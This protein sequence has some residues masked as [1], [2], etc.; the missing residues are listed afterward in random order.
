MVVANPA[1]LLTIGK[2]TPLAT[3]WQLFLVSKFPLE[4]KLVC[5]ILSACH[6][7]INLSVGLVFSKLHLVNNFF[8]IIYY[9]TSSLA[10]HKQ[11]VWG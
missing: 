11:L 1:F 3:A 8:G 4:D 2:H 5:V 6:I 9:F 7:N 10:V